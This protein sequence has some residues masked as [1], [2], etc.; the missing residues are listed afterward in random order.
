MIQVRAKTIV[1]KGLLRV[2]R[3]ILNQEKEEKQEMKKK[4][5]KTG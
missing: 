2:L 4:A 3:E 5:G 1:N